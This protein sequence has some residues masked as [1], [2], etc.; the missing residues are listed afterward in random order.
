M[1]IKETVTYHTGSL[2]S[3]PF[4]GTVHAMCG[5]VANHKQT[6]YV[7]DVEVEYFRFKN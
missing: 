4:T 7:L 3:E 1:F 6:Q 5:N 2:F